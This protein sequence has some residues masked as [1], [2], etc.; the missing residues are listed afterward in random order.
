VNEIRFAGVGRPAQEM[1][2]N[3]PSLAVTN[4][5]GDSSFLSA[6]PIIYSL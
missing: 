3:E 5:C 1:C 4:I 2:K 6:A